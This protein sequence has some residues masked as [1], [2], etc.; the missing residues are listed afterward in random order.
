MVLILV[1][2]P[3]LMVVPSLMVIPAPLI[4][5]KREFPFVEREL[6]SSSVFPLSWKAFITYTEF[7]FPPP[8]VKAELLELELALFLKSNV[9]VLVPEPKNPLSP[10]VPPLIVAPEFAETSKFP[11]IFPV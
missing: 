11:M 1:L 10:L 3:L 9:R 8:I 2:L 6:R 7:A 4:F 5:E